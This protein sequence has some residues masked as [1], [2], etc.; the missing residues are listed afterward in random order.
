MTLEL[1]SKKLA[2][3]AALVSA[4]RRRGLTGRP[5]AD[6]SAALAKALKSKTSL[7]T[8]TETSPEQ[9][10]HETLEH[11]TKELGVLAALASGDKRRGMTGRQQA[12]GPAALR[13]VEI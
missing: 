3:L 1:G 12:D 5:Q 8:D 10:D 6:G 11:S 7:P 2:G 13:S 9:G 4:E